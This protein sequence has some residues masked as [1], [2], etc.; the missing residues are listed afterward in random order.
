MQGGALVDAVGGPHP[1]GQGI[2]PGLFH[3][4]RRLVRIGPESAGVRQVVFLPPDPAQFRFQRDAAAQGPRPPG[5]GDIL[6]QRQPGAVD[7][8]RGIAGGRRLFQQKEAVPV[9][10]V[11]G[12]I[13]PG[14]G[15]HPFRDP[16]GGFQADI[17]DG[18]GGGLQDHRAAG[19]GGGPGYRLRHFQVFKIEGGDGIA[20]PFGVRQQFP[21][22]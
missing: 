2:H 16:F 10:Q 20:V 11:Q 3:E 8:H 9:I 12:Q 21:R 13:R 5:E 18:G 17:P 6:R 4:R 15:G 22:R 14:L 1:Y 7:H 19:R